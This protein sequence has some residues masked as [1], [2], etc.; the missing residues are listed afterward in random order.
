MRY[1]IYVF[2]LLSVSTAAFG[3]AGAAVTKTTVSYS[4]HAC[5]TLVA[6]GLVQLHQ[7]EGSVHRTRSSTALPKPCILMN[8]RVAKVSCQ[9]ISIQ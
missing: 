5:L 7:R 2:L 4:T 8:S 1:F 3:A 9:T 6:D